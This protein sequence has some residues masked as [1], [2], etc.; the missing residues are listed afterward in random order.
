VTKAR[1]SDGQDRAASQSHGRR[2]RRT[3]VAF[4]SLVALT[5]V[6]VAAFTSEPSSVG[7]SHPAAPVHRR[8]SVTGHRAKTNALA[9]DVT[10]PQPT[11]D[12]PAPGLLVPSGQNQSDPVV[13][14]DYGR[15]YLYTSGEPNQPF[16]NIPVASSTNFTQW[17]PVTDALPVLPSW[18]VPGFTWAPDVHRFGGLYVLYFTAIVKGTSPA[19]ECIGSATAFS[20]VG[21]FTPSQ[22]PFI[23][24][25]NQGG[26]IDPRVFTDSDGTNWMLFK[27]DQNIGG[28][29]VPTRIWSQPL[30]PDGLSLTGVPVDILGP[31]EPWEG[32][33]VEAPDLVRVNDTYWLF[34]S[35]NWFNQPQYAIGAARCTG[36]AGP[37]DE[38]ST[39]PLLASNLQGVGP[40]E[41]SILSTP[42]GVWML[43]TPVKSKAPKPDIPLRPVYIVRLG[44]KTTGP[45][46][47]TG[48]LPPVLQP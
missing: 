35:A 30:A 45:Y 33:V 25:S 27:S 13:I 9:D 11:T 34:Y 18:A 20:A 22:T 3:V 44:F 10:V 41:E 47:A 8:A 46:L 15:Y 21:P 14:S 32:T 23:C 5:V 6:M 1:Q 12:P 37:C 4:S 19:M 48:A 31:D 26:S 28:A 7:S 39:A 38:V 40:G 43:Y 36:P 24:Q 17:G 29:S 2:L 16:I 42:T